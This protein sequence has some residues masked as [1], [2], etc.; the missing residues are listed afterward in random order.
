MR[1]NLLLNDNNAIEYYNAPIVSLKYLDNR[2]SAG[3]G[4]CLLRI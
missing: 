3:G 1:R 2:V 4:H